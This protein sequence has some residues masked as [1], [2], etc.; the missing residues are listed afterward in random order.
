MVFR[1]SVDDSGYVI[2]TPG[3]DLRQTEN[4]KEE[5]SPM[6]EMTLGHVCLEYKDRVETPL[7]HHD[8]IT[9]V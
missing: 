3:R 6:L 5:I 2:S 9:M 7:N 1:L 4:P 8:L